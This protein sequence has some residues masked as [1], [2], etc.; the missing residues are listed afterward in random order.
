MN[1]SL[2]TIDWD[3]SFRDLGVEDMWNKFCEVLNSAVDKFVPTQKS[4]IRKY[5]QWMTRAAIRACKLKTKMWKKYQNSKLYNHYVEYIM[6]ANKCTYECKHA[7]RSFET[8]LAKDV[9]T[10]PKAFYSYIRSKSK[11][12]DKVGPRKDKNGQ[13][14]IDD[15]GM[16]N[17]LNDHFRSV[18]TDE[19]D[20][21][22][23][24]RLQDEF[25]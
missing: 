8:K 25:V 2:N 10:N 15:L 22:R 17:I 16:C 11:T 19:K 3:V 12:K 23:L 21:N 13:I 14:V 18:F 24:P 4:K 5:P 9:Q 1:L 20:L 7:K 6:V